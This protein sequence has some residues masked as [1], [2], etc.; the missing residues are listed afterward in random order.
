MMSNKGKKNSFENYSC[1]LQNECN[2]L[3]FL[4]SVRDDREKANDGYFNLKPTS[5]FVQACVRKNKVNMALDEP[6]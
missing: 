3:T 2:A 4:G 1:H 6:N 5:V